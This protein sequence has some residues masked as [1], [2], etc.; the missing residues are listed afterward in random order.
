MKDDVAHYSLLC[1][2]CAVYKRALQDIDDIESEWDVHAFLESR[3]LL[4][5]DIQA[6]HA[7]GWAD[8]ERVTESREVLKTLE[9][10]VCDAIDRRFEQLTQLVKHL[11]RAKKIKETYSVSASP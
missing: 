4:L 5:S 7:E 1:V 3:R 8:S 2:A 9:V 11:R 10:D 6:A